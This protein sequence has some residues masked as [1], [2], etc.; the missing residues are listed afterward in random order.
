M[1]NGNVP[2]TFSGSG[3]NGVKIYNA[4]QG[5]GGTSS[6][7]ISRA[8]STYTYD[9]T[10]NQTHWAQSYNTG[11]TGTGHQ[12]LPPFYSQTNS[13]TYVEIY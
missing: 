10:N 7:T 9:A 2:N 1:M 11:L 12:N 13:T 8:F 3:W 4:G 6:Q 5:F